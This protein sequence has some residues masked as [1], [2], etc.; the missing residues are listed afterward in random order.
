VSG[1][2]GRKDQAGNVIVQTYNPSHPVFADVGL[3]DYLSF[4]NREIAERERWAYPPFVHL[5]KITVKHHNRATVRHAAIELAKRLRVRIT[6]GILG[7]AEPH[8]GKVRNQ[9]IMHLGLKIGRVTGR[10]AQVKAILLDEIATLKRQKG[11]TTVRVNVDVDP[12]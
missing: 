4:Y 6:R 10:S 11:M 8:V 5:I 7:P 9:Y 12:G 2:A 1:R 3:N